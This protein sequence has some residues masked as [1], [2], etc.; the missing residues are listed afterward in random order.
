M[1]VSKLNALHALASSICGACPE[2]TPVITHVDWRP[3][4]I[5]LKKGSIRGFHPGLRRGTAIPFESLHECDVICAL[6]AQPGLL[7]IES[8]PFTIHFEID[9]ARHRYTPDLMLEF[10]EVP[11]CLEPLGF[12]RLTLVECKPRSKLRDSSQALLRARAALQ[13]MSSAPLIVVVDAQLTPAVWEEVAH[14]A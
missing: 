13:V 7:H 10:S 5:P 3:R 14:A 1:L 4:E 11:A 12:E 9:G 2:S 6:I 8:Q